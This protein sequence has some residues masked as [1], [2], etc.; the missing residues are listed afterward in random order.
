MSDKKHVSKKRV[1]ANGRPAPASCSA[2]GETTRVIRPNGLCCC[3]DYDE[4][5]KKPNTQ[6]RDDHE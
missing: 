6:L 3:C 2:C 1:A 5:I 4:N